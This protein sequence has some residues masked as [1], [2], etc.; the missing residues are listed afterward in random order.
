M[1]VRIKDDDKFNAVFGADCFRKYW[2]E[3]YNKTG[4]KVKKF[5]NWWYIWN[6]ETDWMASDTAFFT[7]D[8][9]KCLEIV[10]NRDSKGRFT[11]E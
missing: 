1:R 10:R 7:V 11:N 8:D 3:L 5:G 2:P 4:V 6:E 9:F